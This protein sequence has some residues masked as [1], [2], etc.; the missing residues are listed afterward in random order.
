[1]ITKS[2][3]V[4][5]IS[6][7][8]LLYFFCGIIVYMYLVACCEQWLGS[9]SLPCSGITF[10][11]FLMLLNVR[12]CRPI[13]LSGTLCHVPFPTLQVSICAELHRDLCCVYVTRSYP[14][15]LFRMTELNFGPLNVAYGY[16]IP[17]D[18]S[19]NTYFLCKI[20]AL[21]L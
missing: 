7:V 20:F 21:R 19:V 5:H 3:I 9:C 18:Q 17:Q 10:H 14:I 15:S 12:E 11:D 6:S 4:L 1:M 13:V 16:N 8:D 2:Y